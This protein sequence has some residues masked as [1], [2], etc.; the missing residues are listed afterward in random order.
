MI[1][2]E[3]RMTSDEIETFPGLFIDDFEVT[4]P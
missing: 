4:V 3:F 1:K 2:I